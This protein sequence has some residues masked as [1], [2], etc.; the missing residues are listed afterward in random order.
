VKKVP[1]LIAVSLGLL[2]S[3]KKNSGS[4]NSYHFTATI[5]GK[6]QTFNVT[7][8]ATRISAY[9]A[10]EIAIEGF[11]GTGASNVQALSIGWTATPPSTTKFGTGAWSD[12]SQNYSTIGTY[13]VST[14]EQYVSG[15]GV[16]GVATLSGTKGINDLKIVITS[17]DSTAV[18]GTFSGD[19]YLMGD[20]TGTKRT[21]TNGDF[22]VA[23]K[24]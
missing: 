20:I 12:T 9:G 13:V 16:T 10:T 3:C 21:I 8:L 2:L 15:S 4:S 14:S 24:K 6:A 5:D 18:K 7:P 23:W 17:M 22:Y 1:F 11:N 19:F